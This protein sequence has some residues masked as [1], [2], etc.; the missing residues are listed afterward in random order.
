MLCGVETLQQSSYC[1]AVAENFNGTSPVGRNLHHQC[2]G[3]MC[4]VWD[5]IQSDLT[6]AALAAEVHYLMTLKGAALN[7]GNGLEYPVAPL[8]K[9]TAKLTL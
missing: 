6:I 4:C 3:R 9:N 7:G 8:R 1:W 2:I 5:Q